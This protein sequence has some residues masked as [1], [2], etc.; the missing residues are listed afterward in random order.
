LARLAPLLAIAGLGSA[1]ALLAGR[2]ILSFLPPLNPDAPAWLLPALQRWAPDPALRREASLLLAARL[3]GDPAG[4]HRLLQAQGWGLDPLA[5]VVLKRDAQALTALGSAA[6]AE[7]RWRQ[8][9][10]RFPSAPASADAL[11]ILGRR[12]PGLRQQLLQR[13][14]AHPAALAAAQE[15]DD[16]AAAL[17]LARWGVRWPG[18]EARVR[19]RCAA[20]RPLLQPAERDQLARALAQ[21]GDGEAGLTC[22]REVPPSA[23]TQLAIGRSLI[24]RPGDTDQRGEALLLQLALAHPATAEAREAVELLSESGTASSLAALSQLPAALQQSAPVA[25]R[26]A[27]SS[28]GTSSTLAVLHRWPADPASWELQWQR[29]RLAL[30]QGRWQEAISLLSEPR[31]AAQ[32]PPLLASRRLFWLGFSHWRQ[33]QRQQAT[34]LWRDLLRRHPGGYY[35]WRAATRL[36]REAMEPDRPAEPGSGLWQPLASGDAEL[37][38]LWRLDQPLE[39]WE[40]W[41]HRRGAQ[42]PA[43]AEG[44]LVEGRLRRAVGDHW[45]GLAQLEQASLRLPAGACSEATLLERALHEKAQLPALERASRQTGVSTDLLAAV[46]KQESRF[47]PGVRSAAGAVGLLQLMPETAAELAGGPLADSE[48]QDP[49]RNAVLGA[50]YLHQLQRQWNGNP[51]LVAASYNAGPG[52]VASWISPLLDRAP[53]LWVEAIPYPET[54]LYVKK[55]TGNLWSFQEPRLPR[56]PG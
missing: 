19:Q 2:A 10:Q 31:S 50:R 25:A 33:G 27:L 39:A 12:Q 42:L 20:D 40:H 46:A 47:T 11:Y 16:P 44:L 43:T 14:P 28:E 24:V 45:M 51:L 1:A 5:A 52:A 48:L 38:R 6:A 15:A 17:H 53:E 49:D 54:R 56:C 3:G 26:R 30:L 37:D 7:H 8:L 35:G 55:V 13:F 29:A 34:A 36:G 18:A 4:Q 9:Q 21:L 22:L 23:A 32:Q 41:R